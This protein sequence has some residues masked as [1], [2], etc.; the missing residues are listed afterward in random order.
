MSKKTT[1][2]EKR[3]MNYSALAGTLAVAAGSADAQ[4]VYT[5]VN[6]DQTFNTVGAVYNLDL[7]NDLTPDFPLT[8]QSATGTYLGGLVNYAI[9]GAGLIT[10]SSNEI[11]G[12][13]GAYANYASALNFGDTVSDIQNFISAPLA[14]SSSQGGAL[15]GA[16][17]VITG[18]YSTTLGQGQ[19]IGQS[20]KFIGLKLISGGSTYHGWARVDVS[21][22]GS[23]FTVKD[24]A[25]ESVANAQIICGD[26]GG[27]MITSVNPDQLLKD[28]RTYYYGGNVMVDV[29]GDLSQSGQVIVMNSAG[30][31]VREYGLQTGRNR[32]DVSDLSSGIYM[33]ATRFNEGEE[34]RKIMIR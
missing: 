34:V 31:T 1:T 5:D 25:Y 16:N 26:T 18:I 14:T 23:S 11:V 7:N 21:L 27:G 9:L 20:D 12:Y 3:L 22:D 24:Y 2:L 28:V 29:G 33:V 8:V 19:F 13:A 15:L 10:A 4:V 6:P 17:V 32:F 30:Q